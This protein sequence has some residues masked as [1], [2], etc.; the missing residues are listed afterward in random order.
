MAR[1]SLQSDQLRALENDWQIVD[2]ITLTKGVYPSALVAAERKQKNAT[3][4]AS[5]AKV[6]VYN[7]MRIHRTLEVT[8]MKNTTTVQAC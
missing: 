3:G 2:E 4:N 8:M 6:G 1:E 7:F 5:I